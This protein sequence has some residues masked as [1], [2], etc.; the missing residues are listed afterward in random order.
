MYFCLGF[1]FV[2]C[3]FFFLVSFLGRGCL[4]LVCFLVFLV[5]VVWSSVFVCWYVDVFVAFFDAVLCAGWWIR[6][7][8]VWFG[9]VFCCFGFR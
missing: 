5:V 7:P 6:V 1:G 2:L 3:F 9:L 8:M 4:F